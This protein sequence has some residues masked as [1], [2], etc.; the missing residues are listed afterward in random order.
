MILESMLIKKDEFIGNNAVK[1]TLFSSNISDFDD[2]VEYSEYDFESEMPSEKPE[3]ISCTNYQDFNNDESF[4]KNNCLI[5]KRLNLR[6]HIFQIT[7]IFQQ[8]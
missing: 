3:F 1:Q 2:D 4:S 6:T 7:A 5:N 8:Y